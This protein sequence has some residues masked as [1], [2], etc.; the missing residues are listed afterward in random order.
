M[1]I[2][3]DVVLALKGTLFAAE[4]ML[5]LN[6]RIEPRTAKAYLQQVDVVRKWMREQALEVPHA[7]GG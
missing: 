1:P 3:N 6:P 4:T 2:P 7:P 5:H